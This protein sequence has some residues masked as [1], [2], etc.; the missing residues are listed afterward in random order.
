MARRNGWSIDPLVLA[1]LPPDLELTVT[2]TVGDLRAAQ[3]AVGAV[4]EMAST[5]ELSRAWGFS[6]G[7]WREWAASK[8]VVG[9]VKDDAGDWRLPR[10]AA[11]EQ[12]E[13]ALG[14]DVPRVKSTT[15]LPAAH[16]PRKKAI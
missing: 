2:I 11:R 8:K 15:H 3:V 13:R 6:V 10:E 1:A 4:P 7:Q 12:F 9:A 14:R 16:G 5:R